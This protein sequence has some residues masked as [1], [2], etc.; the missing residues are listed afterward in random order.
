MIADRTDSQRLET[1]VFLFTDIQGSTVR[2]ERHGEAMAAA[3]RRHDDL[4][5]AAMAAHDGQVFKAVG[6][7]FCVAFASV[8]GAIAAAVAAQRALAREDFSEV[9][10]IAVRMAI[11]GGPVEA[12]GGDY[13][14]PPLNRVARLLSTAHGGQILLSGV[15]AGLARQTLPAGLELHDLGMHR[16]KDLGDAEHVFQL[17]APELHREFPA[18]RSLDS[19]PN[20]LPAQAT[21]FVGRETE[22]E[23][24]SRRIT[25]TR[26][27]S[28]VGPPGVGKTR[29]ALHLAAD[30]LAEYPGGAWFVDLSP[31]E[32]DEAVAAAVGA[33]LSLRPS[34][35]RDMTVA[36][37][38][39]VGDKR[40]LL[41]VDCAERIVGAVATFVDALVGVCPN[42]TV[43]VTS[44]QALEV[45][46]ENVY[47]VQT[48]DVPPESAERA[49]DVAAFGAAQLFVE[50]ARAASNRFALTD[51]NAAAVGQICRRLDGI[52]L[53]L[54]LAASKAALLS[55]ADISRR[56]EER[57]R[58]L[59]QTNRTRLPRQQTLRALIDWSYDLLDERERTVFR[60][61]SVFAGSWSMRAA[62]EICSDDA[63]DAWQ[64]FELVA[65][66]QAKS[67]VNA[68]P[69]GDEHRY[70]MLNSIRDYGRERLAESEDGAGVLEAKHTAFYADLVRGLKPLV[71]AL[72]DVRWKAALAPE[73]DNVRAALDWS[74]FSGNDR[75]AAL[76]MLEFFEWPELLTT[77]QEAMRWFDEAARHLVEIESPVGALRIR[78]HRARLEWLVGRAHAEREATATEA[79]AAAEAAGDPDELARALA[80]LAACY[81][82]AG[83]FDDAVPFLERAY[84]AH[85]SLSTP[86]LNEV[87][88]RWAVTDLQRG[89]LE[90]ARQRFT[91]V[92]RLERP[93]SEAHASAMLNLGEL[94]FAAGNAS[95]ARAAAEEARQ[96]YA[97][98]D[99]SP[100]GLTL[101]NLAA[102]AMAEEQYEDA[103]AFLREGL[104]VLKRSGTHWLVIAVEHHAVLG[105]LSGDRERA[106]TLIGFSE[107]RFKA[108]GYSRERTERH[109]YERLMHILREAFAEEDLR[110]R[111]E[112]GA[113]LAEDEALALADA[114]SRLTD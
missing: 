15:A 29:L 92:A 90:S 51:Q 107:S 71:D 73:L 10:G 72:E 87:L 17:R 82:H 24:L 80:T 3:L 74:L 8:S 106:V 6:D 53:A 32:Q 7:Q 79:V 16:L 68:E 5:N 61:L 39:H 62:T 54:E 69:G 78:R 91:V 60:R 12:R 56:L 28:L 102:Y 109:G 44:R 27:L 40:M 86:A 58:L 110:S 95:A 14:G 59:T 26:L 65:L 31:V 34:P 43:L 48:L 37:V 101:C 64:V 9:E 1:V 19:F 98:L 103:R 113:R 112:R 47:H 13:F 36:I 57:F 42:A 89:D 111:M 104:R 33:A 45:V 97:R 18:L 88:R 4:M 85:K 23:E 50:R 66:I 99:A 2:W 55:A 93:G 77:P 83:R 114:I 38:D 52:P 75:R 67:L 20:N 46:G 30:L 105:G 70:H 84:A 63:I 22:L 100:L 25:E 94:E 11:H 49:N 96:T 35:G 108:Q 41:I 76:R 81:M 21:R